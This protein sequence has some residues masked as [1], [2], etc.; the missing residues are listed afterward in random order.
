MAQVSLELPDLGNSL[1]LSASW[2]VYDSLFS[3]C[4]FIPDGHDWIIWKIWGGGCHRGSSPTA[5][6]T[7]L[8]VHSERWIRSLELPL[9]LHQV[10]L[11]DFT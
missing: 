8:L 11:Q 3:F 5:E 10:G 4:C 9:T 6:S 2:E 1:P 7:E